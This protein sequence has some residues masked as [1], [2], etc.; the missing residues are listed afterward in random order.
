MGAAVSLDTFRSIRRRY[1]RSYGK[2]LLRKFDRFLAEQSLV[3]NDPVL[4]ASLLPWTGMLEDNWR[5]IRSELDNILRYREEIPRFQ[6]LSPDQYKISP[7]DMWKTFALFGFGYRSELNCKLCPKTTAILEKIPD[8]KTAFFS[9]LAPGKHV[10]RHKGV[11]K[12]FVRCHLGLIVPREKEK[13]FMDV[14]GNTCVW[15]EG[16]AFVF[17]DTFPHEVYNDTAEERVVLLIDVERPM[18]RK[19]L[20]AS[21]LAMWILRR[22]AYVVDARRNQEIWEKRLRAKLQ[23]EGNSV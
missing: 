21:R 4:D 7:D 10:P 16:H 22:T 3:P 15:E 6:D 8:L 17:D 11:T 20:V 14:D 2:P 13:C 23:A 9:I 1:V 19:G 5:D 18:T 12:G